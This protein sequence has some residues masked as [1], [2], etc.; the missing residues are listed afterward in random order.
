M[1]EKM[2]ITFHYDEDADILY[3]DFGSDEP[4]YTDALDGSL[5]IDIGWFSNLPRGAKIMSP[6]ARNIKSV[7]VVFGQITKA[8]QKLMEKQAQLIHT[9]E[10][11]FENI[12]NQQINRAFSCVN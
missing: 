11:I 10:P 9:T 1:A 5:M 6:K 8:C 7:Q 4:C 12:L 3:L 2:N